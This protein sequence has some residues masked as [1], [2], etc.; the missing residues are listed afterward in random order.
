VACVSCGAHPFCLILLYRELIGSVLEY[1]SV[2][3]TNMIKTHMLCLERVQYRALWIA[4]G[5]MLLS[6]LFSLNY[7]ILLRLYS[8]WSD[9]LFSLIAWVRSRLCCLGKLRITHPLVYECKQLW[10]SLCQNRIEVKLNWIPSH[11][12]L[13]GN[14]LFDG[15]PD[16]TYRPWF[17][18]QKEERSFVCTVSRV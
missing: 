6:T 17:E 18:D 15:R 2:C 8:L 7:D 14:K 13:V 11:V 1:G 16:V 5:L 3:F 4:L 10:W 9:L 12:G